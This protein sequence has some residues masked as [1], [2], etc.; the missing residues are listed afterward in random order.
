MIINKIK[1]F[2]SVKI[3]IRQTCAKVEYF[4]RKNHKKMHFFKAYM[5]GTL[6][7]SDFSRS[8]E[9]GVSTKKDPKIFSDPEVLGYAWTMSV[10]CC[11]LTV[12]LSINNHFLCF[13]AIAVDN[14]NN[15]CCIVEF[16]YADSV[17]AV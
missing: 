11:P 9:L 8:W 5:L 1:I 2:V 14:S 13:N 10:D 3:W 16:A 6:R 7:T 17:A 12:V 15:V 4:F